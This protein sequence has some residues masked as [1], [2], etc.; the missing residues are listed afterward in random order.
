MIKPR[1]EFHYLKAIHK[2]PK[3]D[4]DKILMKIFQDWRKTRYDRVK[5]G[6]MA[7]DPYYHHIGAIYKTGQLWELYQAFLGK[8]K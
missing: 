5:G 7:K 4:K 2:T 3:M 8:K 6:W 1:S